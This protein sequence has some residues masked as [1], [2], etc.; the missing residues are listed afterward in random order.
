MCLRWG[1]SAA[2]QE[3]PSGVSCQQLA[4]LRCF[5]RPRTAWRRP[6]AV[7]SEQSAVAGCDLGFVAARQ[8]RT[9][10][11]AP[12]LAPGYLRLAGLCRGR[13]LDTCK[14]GH[15]PPRLR[16]PASRADPAFF[17]HHD[18]PRL[19]RL[20][21]RGQSLRSHRG[22]GSSEATSE[23][24]R[25]ARLGAASSTFTGGTSSGAGRRS[26]RSSPIPIR[27]HTRRRPGRRCAASRA[28]R[29]PTPAPKYGPHDPDCDAVHR[30]GPHPSVHLVLY[31]R[32]RARS[33]GRFLLARAGGV[34]P[35]E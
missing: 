14:T 30:V 29:A 11:G 34:K 5:P 31:H 7:P 1:E 20:R 9:Y 33:G 24:A 26:E 19:K 17:E 6:V 15:S 13:L 3:Q 16:E 23:I 2:E 28:D 32:A 10:H 12:A 18:A 4:A 8:T 27:W 21:E 35:R 25:S 22:A